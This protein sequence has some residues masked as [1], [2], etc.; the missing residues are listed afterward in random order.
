MT[1]KKVPINKL[2]DIP[3]IGPA[4]V[5]DFAVLGITKPAELVGCDPYFLYMQLCARTGKRHDPCVCDTFIA[6]V[7][8]METGKKKPWWAFTKERKAYFAKHG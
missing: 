6:A 5:R 1:N 2:T 4:M 7:R 3:N 8:F